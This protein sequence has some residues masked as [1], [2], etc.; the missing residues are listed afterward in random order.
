[1]LYQNVLGVK[2]TFSF[3]Y[4]RPNFGNFCTKMIF[5]SQQYFMITNIDNR[6][7]KPAMDLQDIQV[8]KKPTMGIDKFVQMKILHHWTTLDCS[9]RTIVIV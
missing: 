2:E 3:P 6:I 4:T 7:G 9:V 5:H 8:S 1:M